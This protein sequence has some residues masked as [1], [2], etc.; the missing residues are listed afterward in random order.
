MRAFDIRK[1]PHCEFVALKWHYKK[2]KK[3]NNMSVTSYSP[4]TKI[5]V[6]QNEQ[7]LN[8]CIEKFHI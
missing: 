5:F 8:L 6:S 7:I 1:D 4:S 2:K 3:M